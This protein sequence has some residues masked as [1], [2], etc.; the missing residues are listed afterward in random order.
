MA[1]GCKMP[2]LTV[3]ESNTVISVLEKFIA[4]LDPE[5]EDTAKLLERLQSA[6]SKLTKYT[7]TPFSCTTVADLQNLQIHSAGLVFKDDNARARAR[8]QGARE[9]DGNDMT[10]ETTKS[11]FRLTR[12]HF[13]CASEAG[14]RM[15]I[16]VILLRLVSMLSHT[17][18]RLLIL[19]EFNTAATPLDI[20]RPDLAQVGSS[21]IFEAKD[22]AMLKDHFP[23]VIAAM[24]T[25]CQIHKKERARGVITCGDHWL[26]FAFKTRNDTQNKPARYARSPVLEIG[27]GEEDLDLILGIL[28]DWVQH[29][30]EFEEQEYFCHL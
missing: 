30:H 3:E 12:T 25:W 15:L 18:N 28:V 22:I 29:P 13:W 5:D 19:P 24:A 10:F 23:Q 9:V 6:T 20:S 8:L 16:N 11:L 4:A 27:E 7:H 14:S 21:I 2:D 17:E 1:R 26:F